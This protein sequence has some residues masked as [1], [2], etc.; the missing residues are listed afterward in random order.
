MAVGASGAGAS[1][2]GPAQ[3]WT[4]FSCQPM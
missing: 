4:G 3:C 2:S 1:M